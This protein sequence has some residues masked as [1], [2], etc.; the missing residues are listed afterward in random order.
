MKQIIEILKERDGL[1]VT[2]AIN[3]VKE[4]QDLIF[5]SLEGDY[6]IDEIDGIVAA[7]LGLEPDFIEPLINHRI[8]IFSFEQWDFAINRIAK[9]HEVKSKMSKGIIHYQVD[10]GEW[11]DVY[12]MDGMVAMI[13]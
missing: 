3:L 9:E 5:S 1:S 8:R 7:N 6:S 2:E 12:L 4:T 11:K 13:A 10:G